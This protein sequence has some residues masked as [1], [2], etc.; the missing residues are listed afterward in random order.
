MLKNLLVAAGFIVSA[1][2]AQ[3]AMPE[4]SDAAAQVGS[5]LKIA[6]DAGQQVASVV[7]GEAAASNDAES[8][9]LANTVAAPAIPEPETYAL[10]LAGLAAVGFVIRRCP[11]TRFAGSG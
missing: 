3:A 2:G 10:M 9:N 4:A 1:V 6:A 5:F 11:A 7:N 8:P